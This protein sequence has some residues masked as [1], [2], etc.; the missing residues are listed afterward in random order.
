MGIY[1]R[2]DCLRI[3]FAGKASLAIRVAHID[4][5]GGNLVCTHPQDSHAHHKVFAIEKYQKKNRKMGRKMKQHSS[6]LLHTLLL[7]FPPIPAEVCVQKNER[8]QGKMV[9]RS[10]SGQRKKRFGVARDLC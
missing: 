4:N 9:D 6:Y 3:V 2:E 1:R 7:C 8:G 10:T 5:N